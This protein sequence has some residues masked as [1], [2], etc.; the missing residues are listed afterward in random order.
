MKNNSLFSTDFDINE[1]N[2][3]NN[4]VKTADVLA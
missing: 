3:N 1:E 4:G 2:E